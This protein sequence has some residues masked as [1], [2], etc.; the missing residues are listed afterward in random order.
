MNSLTKQQQN[1]A[2]QIAG[3]IQNYRKVTTRTGKPMASFTVGTFPAKCFDVL[4]D[5]C[6]I[7][8]C[9]RVHATPAEVKEYTQ[10]TPHKVILNRIGVHAVSR[11][12]NQGVIL[13]VSCLDFIY[14]LPK[15][16]R[17]DF[18]C[19]RAENPPVPLLQL[20]CEFI[21]NRREGESGIPEEL[22]RFF[23]ICHRCSSSNLRRFLKLGSN[24]ALA[25]PTATP[26][27]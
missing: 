27:Y 4:V 16:V 13:N 24:L 21:G 18:D 17:S 11:M 6:R 14:I 22:F 3:I 20:G 5:S 9:V 2:L 23:D 8:L 26:S 19:S 10:G 1:P 12:R 25:G 7:F 15:I